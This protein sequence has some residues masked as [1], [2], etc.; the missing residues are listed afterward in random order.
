MNESA[1]VKGGRL[2]FSG[3]VNRHPYLHITCEGSQ[4]NPLNAFTICN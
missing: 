1:A 4:L 3:A 2:F